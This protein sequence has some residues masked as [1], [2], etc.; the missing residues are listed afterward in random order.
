MNR[1]TQ[2]RIEKGYKTMKDAAAAIG[3]PYTTYRGYEQEERG[4][5]SDVVKAFADFYG[6]SMDYV[7]CRSDKRNEQEE[8]DEVM[9]L[10]Q[11]MRERPELSYLMNAYR[12]AKPE[13]VYKALAF[14]EH[15]KEE[16]ENR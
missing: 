5:D 14:L 3:M 1:L 15:L 13:D 4:M 11:A 8:I 12:K 2:L 6:V 7:V 9:D 10:R 16:S